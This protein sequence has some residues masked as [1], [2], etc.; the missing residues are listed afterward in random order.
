MNIF[1]SLTWTWVK[2]FIKLFL[3]SINSTE[4]VIYSTTFY[5][6]LLIPNT[7][8]PAALNLHDFLGD[9]ITSFKLLISKLCSSYGGVNGLTSSSFYNNSLFDPNLIKLL[10]A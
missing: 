3:I 10:V 7:K 5:Y 4:D 6:N 8:L 2:F 1:G 9:C